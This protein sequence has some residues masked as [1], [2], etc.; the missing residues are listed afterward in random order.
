MNPWFNNSCSCRFNSFNS[1]GTILLGALE[2]DVVP[3][4]S[5]MPKLTSCYG[6]NPRN[7]SRKTSKNS[8]TTGITD[9][10]VSTHLTS[11]ALARNTTAPRLIN[12]LTFKAVIV[13]GILPDSLIL[14]LSNFMGFDYKEIEECKYIV[15]QR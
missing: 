1:S 14:E 4:S 8:F 7:S 15:S 11:T 12:F 9:T 5:S 10:S 13:L 6:S 2:I 3:S